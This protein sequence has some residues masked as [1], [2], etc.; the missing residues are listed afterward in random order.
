MQAGQSEWQHLESHVVSPPPIVGEGPIAHELPIWPGH[1]WESPVDMRKQIF[2]NRSLNMKS[3][4]AV[5]FDM[6]Y[7]LAQYK[8]DT[9]E[10]M[11]YAGTTKKL[12][13]NLGYPKDVGFSYPWLDIAILF[14]HISVTI[15]CVTA[16]SV[17]HDFTLWLGFFSLSLFCLLVPLSLIAFKDV[18][19]NS[20]KSSLQ[21]SGSRDYCFLVECWHIGSWTPYLSELCY[22]SL[23]NS[24]LFCSCWNGSLIGSIWSEVLWLTRRGAIFWRWDCTTTRLV[25][26]D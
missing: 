23:T 16:S 6:D 26:V 8:P 9:F 4:V 2:C 25:V 10:S 3:I 11:A 21:W 13:N 5:G 19:V 24:F 17:M 7:T 18:F 1:M 14:L 12:V 20:H 22:V 15:S